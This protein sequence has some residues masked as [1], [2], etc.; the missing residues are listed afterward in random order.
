[1]EN[2]SDRGSFIVEKVRIP[3]HICAT[4]SLSIH[5]WL[6]PYTGYCEQYSNSMGMLSPNSGLQK[7]S[8]TAEENKNI[9][10]FAGQWKELENIILSE[11]THTQKDKHEDLNSIPNTQEEETVPSCRFQEMAVL[12][13]F[14]CVVLVSVLDLAV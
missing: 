7:S 8:W 9:M 10:K 13:G 3:L 14:L 6:V 2:E 11:V 12:I 5:L 1:M 4:F